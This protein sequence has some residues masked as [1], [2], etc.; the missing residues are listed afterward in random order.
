MEACYVDASIWMS[1]VFLHDKHASVESEKLTE[2]SRKQ[3]P[4]ETF[5][6]FSCFYVPMLLPASLPPSAG[7]RFGGPGGDDLTMDGAQQQHEP[8]GSKNL[9][10]RYPMR[11][12]DG[13]V[14]DRCCHCRKRDLS[15]QY[16]GVN[17]NPTILSHSRIF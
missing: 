13:H 11:L 9:C 17:H 15:I 14:Q 12:G 8:D 7:R 3:K 16:T 2:L 5:H 4:G 10:G 6:N 1:D